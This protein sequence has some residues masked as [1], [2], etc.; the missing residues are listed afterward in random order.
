VL[1]AFWGLAIL[2]LTEIIAGAGVYQLATGP[3]DL[4]SIEKGYGNSWVGLLYFSGISFTSLGY[5]QQDAL[6][7]LRLI[8]MVQALMGFMLITWSATFVYSIWQKHFRE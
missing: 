7:A 5:T 3:L 6:G 8:V 4:G 1:I 2:H